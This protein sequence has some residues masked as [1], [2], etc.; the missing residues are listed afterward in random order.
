MEAGGIE[1]PSEDG[2]C[3]A[4]TFLVCVLLP[5][6]QRPQ[7]NFVNWVYDYDLNFKGPQRQ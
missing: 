2:P 4:T 6:L 3:E 7:T 5:S 1:P